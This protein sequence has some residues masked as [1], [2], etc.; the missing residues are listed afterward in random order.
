MSKF[1]RRD[2]QVEASQFTEQQANNPKSWPKGAVATSVR[3]D[4][5]II[6]GVGIPGPDGPLVLRAGDWIVK[7]GDV[8]HVMSDVEFNVRYS[9]G[10][11]EKAEKSWKD[12]KAKK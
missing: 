6:S 1:L 5:H 2:A 10:K 8:T 12:E 3:R 11:D 9:T 4:G 7:D